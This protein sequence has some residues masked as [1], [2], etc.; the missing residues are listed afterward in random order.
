MSSPEQELH[1]AV[2]NLELLTNEELLQWRLDQ[3]VSLADWSERIVE[4]N[5]GWMN[6]VQ[7]IL[8]CDEEIATRGLVK[9]L[10][11]RPMPADLVGPEVPL[12]RIV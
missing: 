8:V 5:Q 12:L 11:E 6:E 2:P 7:G 4:A 1:V 10:H 3:Q 9:T